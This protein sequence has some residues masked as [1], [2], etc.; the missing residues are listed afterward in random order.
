M[1]WTSAI[2]DRLQT[3][4]TAAQ[5]AAEAHNGLDALDPWLSC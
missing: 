5:T 3:I 4:A 1:T 2:R